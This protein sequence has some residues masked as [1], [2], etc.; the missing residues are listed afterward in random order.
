MGQNRF[1][2]GMIGAVLSFLPGRNRK[3]HDIGSSHIPA[4]ERWM[5]PRPAG[6]GRNNRSRSL[7]KLRAKRKTL[8]QITRESR[9]RN[10]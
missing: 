10:R 4:H 8:F 9:R 5:E 2:A 1:M 6:F 3:S 7:T